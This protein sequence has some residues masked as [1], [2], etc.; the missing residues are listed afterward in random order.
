[1]DRSLSLA[2]L[3]KLAAHFAPPKLRCVESWR[4]PGIR[5]QSLEFSGSD[6]TLKF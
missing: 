3:E 6:E 2:K 4:L 1:M 5:L